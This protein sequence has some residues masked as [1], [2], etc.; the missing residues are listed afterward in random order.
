MYQNK[1]RKSKRKK[2]ENSN[3]NR[4]SCRDTSWCMD[5][6]EKVR[7]GIADRLTVEG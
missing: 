1:R 5:K 7:K 2:K 3:V 6:Q 4:D